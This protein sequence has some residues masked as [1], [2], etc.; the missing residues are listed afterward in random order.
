[1]VVP[2][3]F[4]GGYVRSQRMKVIS[5]CASGDA[6]LERRLPV[7]LNLK[8]SCDDTVEGEGRTCRWSC[9]DN[10]KIKRE[11]E[12]W[13]RKRCVGGIDE[14]ATDGEVAKT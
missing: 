7:A 6:Q 5:R 13:S 8:K 3:E 2:E 4:E 12:R 1:M 11:R 14:L 9:I 10:E